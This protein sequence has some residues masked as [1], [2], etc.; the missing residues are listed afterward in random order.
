MPK[1]KDG[2]YKVTVQINKKRYYFMG[3]TLKE[4]KDK[5]SAFLDLLEKCPLATQKSHIVRM[6]AGV[7]RIYNA[8]YIPCHEKRLL[9]YH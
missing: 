8:E 1:R 2:R 6:D 4:A 9:L 7:A 5:R 3:R